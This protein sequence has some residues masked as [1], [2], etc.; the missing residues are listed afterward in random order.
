MTRPESNSTRASRCLA[1]VARYGDD[2]P[3][4]NLIDLL[5]DAMHL[6]DRE[7]FDFTIVLARAFRLYLFE[8]NRNSSD[9]RPA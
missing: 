9:R 1:A 6:C 8:L 7:G 3:E 2:E 5:T 4:D